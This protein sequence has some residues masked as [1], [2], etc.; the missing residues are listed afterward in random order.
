TNDSGNAPAAAPGSALTSFSLDGN[1]PRVYYTG[2]NGHV[3]ELA[4]QNGWGHRDVTNDSGNAPAAATGS[5]LTSFGLGG[6]SPRVYYP[7]TNNHVY[8]LAWL[9]SN[10]AFR[11]VTNDSG[12][13]PAAATGSSL[14]SFGLNNGQ[15]G[16][17]Y[18]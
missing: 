7:G 10:W 11:D 18:I 13:A 12:N 8:E 2:A 4:W 1:R 17:Y 16:V 14:T 9:G 5:S 3:H 6:T 15:P